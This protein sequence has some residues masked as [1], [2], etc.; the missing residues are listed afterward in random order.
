MAHAAKLLRML[1]RMLS[2]QPARS[3]LMESDTFDVSL[4]IVSRARRRRMTMLPEPLSSDCVQQLRRAIRPCSSIQEST[5]STGRVGKIYSRSQRRFWII[6]RRLDLIPRGRFPA[7][8]LP[9]LSDYTVVSNTSS[10]RTTSHSSR[11][12]R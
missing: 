9:I 8:D 12:S 11:R 4:R 3:S 10:G 7:T 6:D 1:R 2:S 5:I